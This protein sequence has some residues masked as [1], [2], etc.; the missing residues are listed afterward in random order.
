MSQ[1]RLDGK[2]ALVTGGG[3][4]IGRAIALLF[5]GEGAKVVVVNR[6]GGGGATVETIRNAGGDAILVEADVSRSTEVEGAVRA[7]VEHYGKIDVL[8]NNAGIFIGG[9]VTEFSEESWDEIIDIN[10]K[11]VF[12]CSKYAAAEMLKSGGGVI[13]NISSAL[14]L[15]GAEGEAAYC[16]CKGGVISFTRAMA[17]DYAKRNIR[18]NCICPGTILT[19]L[20]DQFLVKS[21]NYETAL[22]IEGEKA[23]MGRV[24]K[25]EEVAYMA[26]Y[27]ASD[28]SSYVTG[29]IMTVDGGW[30]AR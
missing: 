22:A 4:G 12:L 30:T 27:L 2:V 23:P 29:S 13:I 6:K 17:L 14:G 19:P 25:P 9:Q 11:G 15:V 16:A 26:L 5:A 24:G 10:L 20:L 1:R 21:E 3:K 28:E 8:V 18:V 7:T